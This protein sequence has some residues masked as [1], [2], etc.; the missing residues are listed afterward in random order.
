MKLLSCLILCCSITACATIDITENTVL[1]PDEKP[2]LASNLSA[3]YVSEAVEV[4]H[5]D[6]ATSRGIYFSSPKSTA[7]VLYFGGNEFRIDRE[8]QSIIES[9][10]K[11]PV[12]IVIF[13]YRG[14]GRS[15]GTPT[16]KLLQSDSLDLF[17]FVKGKTKNKIVVYGLSLGSYIAANVANHEN[18]DGL[19]LEGVS[20]NVKDWA[21][22]LVPWYAKPFVD[23]NIQQTLLGI[24]NVKALKDYTGPLLVLAGQSDELVPVGLQKSLWEQAT[25][26]KKDFHAFP[27]YGH[28]G[29][30]QSED[31]PKVLK[32]F[33]TEEVGV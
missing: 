16:A 10:A 17:R 2:P 28:K 19:V 24:D 6:G 20:T 7:T 9:L 23:I 33:L 12:D 15:D 1:R 31:F 3:G 14:Y 4:T 25:T 11:V 13:D 26:A 22:Q 27:K 18:V 30:I 29:L 21:T 8:S 5:A 32:R